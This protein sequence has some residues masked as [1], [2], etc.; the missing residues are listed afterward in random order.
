MTG[1][2]PAWRFSGKSLLNLDLLI[3]DHNIILVYARGQVVSLNPKTGEKQWQYDHD[4]SLTFAALT[5]RGI[6]LGHR[7]E[8]FFIGE[9]HER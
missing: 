2:S 1:G 8:I 5:Q 3:T 6:L 7:R 9:K 4:E